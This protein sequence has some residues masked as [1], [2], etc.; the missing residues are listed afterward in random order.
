MTDM[1]LIAPFMHTDS[2]ND[3]VARRTP[4][5]QKGTSQAA[6]AVPVDAGDRD[7]AVDGVGYVA[8]TSLASHAKLDEDLLIGAKLRHARMVQK[9]RLKDLAERVGC[10]ES[11]L[12]KV[13]N[14]QVR[15]SLKILHRI[16]AELHTSIGALFSEGGGDHN[17]VVMRR[18]ERPII[19]TDVIGRPTAAGVRL[20]SLVPDPES[21]LLYGSIHIVEPGRGSE[22]D[23]QHKGE[24][25]GYLLEGEL[26]LS[27]DGVTYHL[28]AGDSFFFDSSLPHGY[29]NPGHITTKVVWINTPPTF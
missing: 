9:L 8:G 17:K 2:M 6:H 28:S 4:R 5:K 21:R 13:E 22:G 10:S 1:A 3:A 23:I 26:D 11:M 25:I 15:P 12:S 29:K 16:A 7:H 14:D 24:E 19:R 18:G 27:V 20:E